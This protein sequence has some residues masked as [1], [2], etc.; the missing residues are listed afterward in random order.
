M[1]S[2]RIFFQDQ[3]KKQIFKYLLIAVIIVSIEVLSFALLNSVIKINY[4]VSTVLSMAIGI[5]L[6]WFLSRVYVFKASKYAI[7]TE[8]MMVV[9]ASL[10]GVGIQLSVIWICVEKLSITPI[11]GKIL[12]ILITFSWNFWVRKRYIFNTKNTKNIPPAIEY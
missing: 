1:K 10:V 12:A 5:A 4:L 3:I 11:I 9:L 8:I 6:N 2:L 7:H